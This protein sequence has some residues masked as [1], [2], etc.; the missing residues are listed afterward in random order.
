MII[1]EKKNGKKIAVAN[2]D[3]S[4]P[5][6]IGHTL[7]TEWL[8]IKV[9]ERIIKWK[10]NQYE[11]WCKDAKGD[12][13]LFINAFIPLIVSLFFKENWNKEFPSCMY[14]K[15]KENGKRQHEFQI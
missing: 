7:M 3:H 4:S 12:N 2:G 15:T 11:I 13:L 10:Y 14:E 9:Q 1:K 6:G 5:D 8:I